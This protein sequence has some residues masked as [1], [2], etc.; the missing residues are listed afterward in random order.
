MSRTKYAIIPSGDADS[1]EPSLRLFAVRSC[2]GQ[3]GYIT[4]REVPEVQIAVLGHQARE[5]AHGPAA[6]KTSGTKEVND[7]RTFS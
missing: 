5:A 3:A 7:P 1:E 6:G 2:V 4:P